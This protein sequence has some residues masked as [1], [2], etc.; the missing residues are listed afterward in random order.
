MNN[1]ILSILSQVH[2]NHMTAMRLNS[3]SS[4]QIHIIIVKLE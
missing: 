3:K 2:V 4:T 1:S